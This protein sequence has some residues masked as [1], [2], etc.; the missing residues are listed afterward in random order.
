MSETRI[1][2]PGP[3][4]DMTRLWWLY[5]V[6]GVLWI[7]F[8]MWLW[9]YRVGSLVALAALIGAGAN[10]EWTVADLAFAAPVLER[11]TFK[12]KAPTGCTK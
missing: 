4:R 2:A 11:E 9:S 1:L 8:G 7:L 10:N 3:F 12:L 6:F 5:L